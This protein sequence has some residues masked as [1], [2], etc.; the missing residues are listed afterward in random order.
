M[1]QALTGG[2]PPNLVLPSGYVVRLNAL[3]PTT[4]AQVTGVRVTNASFQV[5]PINIGA[6]GTGGDDFTLPLLVPVT[7]T[8]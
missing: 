6:G 2:L 7:E 5:R 3:D 8:G 1:A 4:G